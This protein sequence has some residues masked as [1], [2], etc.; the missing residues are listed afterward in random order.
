M[1]FI[2]CLFI[3]Y[4]LVTDQKVLQKDIE[5]LHLEVLE[6]DENGI[7]IIGAFSSVWHEKHLP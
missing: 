2:V 5:D 6:F 7:A 4:T 1:C 3:D